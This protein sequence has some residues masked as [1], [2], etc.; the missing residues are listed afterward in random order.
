LKVKSNFPK[1][2]VCYHGHDWN[3]CEEKIASQAS[4]DFKRLLKATT[5]ERTSL[6]EMELINKT[7]EFYLR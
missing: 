5:V 4:I 7:E 3:D 1:L 2:A 6:S